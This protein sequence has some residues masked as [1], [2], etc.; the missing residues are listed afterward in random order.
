MRRVTPIAAL[1]CIGS[2]MS[3][4]PASAQIVNSELG[5]IGDGVG[6]SANAINSS[7]VIVG[8][9][10]H[11]SAPTN[12]AAVWV[13]G[14]GTLLDLGCP[15]CSSVANDINDAGDIVGFVGANAFV[16]S[17]GGSLTILPPLPGHTIAVARAI[18][19]LGVV[20]GQ[21]S[22]NSSG[23]L[24]NSSR[25]VRWINGEPES[26]GLLGNS[27]GPLSGSAESITDS[28]IIVG[29]ATHATGPNHAFKWEGGFMTDLGT[30]PGTSPCGMVSTANG[31]NE[32]GGIVGTSTEASTGPP[33]PSAPCTSKPVRWINGVIEALPASTFGSALDINEN[34]DIVGNTGISGGQTATLWRDGQR[35]TLETLTGFTQSIAGDIND[36]GVIAARSFNGGVNQNVPPR[37]HAITITAANTPPS[38]NLPGNMVVNADSPGGAHVFFSATADDAEDGTFNAVC[39]PAR[40]S[41]FPNGSTTVSCDATDSGGLQ[42]TGSFTITVKGAAEQ[43]QDLVTVV[44][45]SGPGSSLQNKLAAILTSLA[46]NDDQ[47]CQK[48][49]AFM[50][51][52]S[53]QSGKKLSAAQAA[54]LIASA[55]RIRAVAGC[56]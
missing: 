41:L 52:V 8:I 7:G 27:G 28:G 5:L 56:N 49:L 6:H 22:L 3:V 16:V 36:A 48:L 29:H 13:N 20:V 24:A 39:T 18:N 44:G 55:N 25:P 43:A 46:S 21:S 32:A 15:A 45:A 17:S 38:L 37:A 11:S 14:V 54:A 31:I 50:N 23:P 26:L 42:A 35:I 2:L 33:S 40:G 53:A 51:E 34:G 30:L 1:I 47:S 19:N 10:V 9:S 12:R 4:S